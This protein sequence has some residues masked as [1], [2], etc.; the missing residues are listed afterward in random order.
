MQTS[1]KKSICVKKYAFYA[2]LKGLEKGLGLIIFE[3]NEQKVNGVKIGIGKTEKFS[4]DRKTF[5]SLLAYEYI[6]YVESL[7]KN[8]WKEFKKIYDQYK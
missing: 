3:E 1:N 2:Y 8:V 6:E 7:P 5:E 4:F